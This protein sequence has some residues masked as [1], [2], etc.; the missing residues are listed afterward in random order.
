MCQ[1]KP[2]GDQEWGPK[3]STSEQHP[4]HST[5]AQAHLSPPG[6]QLTDTAPKSLFNRCTGVES[7]IP[8]EGLSM[9]LPKVLAHADPT[10]SEK[11]FSAISSLQHCRWLPEL[12]ASAFTRPFLTLQQSQPFCLGDAR[13]LEL[14]SYHCGNPM[15][16]QPQNLCTNFYVHFSSF[17]LWIGAPLY[18]ERH[19]GLLIVQEVFVQDVL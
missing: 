8:M 10:R 15:F 1:A 19:A 4:I 5:P 2:L 3:S 11:P 13:E 6:N 14:P 18:L 9:Q 12:L 7:V 17:A 16:R